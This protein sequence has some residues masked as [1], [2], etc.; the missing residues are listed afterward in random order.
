M[1]VCIHVYVYVCVC[2]FMAAADWV[3]SSYIF[4]FGSPRGSFRFA[5]PFYI[6]HVLTNRIALLVTRKNITIHRSAAR[7]S[8]CTRRPLPSSATLW[9]RRCVCVWICDCICYVDQKKRRVCCRLS[10][11]VRVCV[12]MDSVGCAVRWQL[13]R[14]T[15]WLA[16]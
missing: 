6:P 10:P 7:P 14:L 1:D 11:C 3:G 15:G 13:D 9:A 16:D 5:C 4:P 2:S 12:V 8:R